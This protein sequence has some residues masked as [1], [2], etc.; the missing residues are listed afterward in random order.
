[1]EARVTYAY[2]IGRDATVEAKT[3]EPTAMVLVR[4]ATAAM[5]RGGTRSSMISYRMLF[6]PP[7]LVTRSTIA[8]LPTIEL[9]T[10]VIKSA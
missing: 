4:I 7:T 2:S 1:M 10:K 9:S 5:F 6:Q 3:P 8:I